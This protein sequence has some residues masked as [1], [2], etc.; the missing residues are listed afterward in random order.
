[1][2]KRY[3]LYTSGLPFTRARWRRFYVKNQIFITMCMECAYLDNLKMQQHKKRGNDVDENLIATNAVKHIGNHNVVVQQNTKKKYVRNI[4]MFW[5]GIARANLLHDVKKKAQRAD[6]TDD[7]SG[8]SETK[9]S[10]NSS[11]V[12]NVI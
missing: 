2:V 1:M 4:I 3:R 10:H 7:S 11:R 6:D 5:I 12:A 9:R 8:S